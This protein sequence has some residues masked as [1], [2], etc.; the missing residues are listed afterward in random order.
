MVAKWLHPRGAIELAIPTLAERVAP[1]VRGDRGAQA[2][3][4]WGHEDGKTAAGLGV[5]SAYS[6]HIRRSGRQRPSIAPRPLPL[7]IC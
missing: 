6:F 7:L 2:Q 4:D 1:P 3:V 5:R